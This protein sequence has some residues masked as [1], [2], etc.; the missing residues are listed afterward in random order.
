MRSLF[1]L[2]I[3]RGR[4]TLPSIG[5][6]PRTP[7]SAQLPQ[8]PRS[9]PTDSPAIQPIFLKG[10]HIHPDVIA[11]FRYSIYTYV[12]A[13]DTPAAWLLSYINEA[14]HGE[15]SLGGQLAPGSAAVVSAL[16]WYRGRRRAVFVLAQLC[17]STANCARNTW[18]WCFAS[19]LPA[20]PVVSR[21]D[22]GRRRHGRVRSPLVS[23]VLPR[24]SPVVQ[25]HTARTRASLSLMDLPY[26][27]GESHRL[28]CHWTSRC[29]L[30]DGSAAETRRI[31]APF[32]SLGAAPHSC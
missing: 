24:R 14:E 19:S 11:R 3:R 27:R 1:R 23:R 17:A 28:L 22:G 25:L 21:W 29:A 30:V 6:R 7:R 9:P 32:V 16:L 15:S 18:S 20:A 13:G 26:R 2:A 12:F 8:S 5:Q 10:A 4:Y 31:A